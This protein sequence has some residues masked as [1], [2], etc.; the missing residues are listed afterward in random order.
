MPAY[1]RSRAHEILRER[2]GL[3]ELRP[4]QE[5]VIA[6]VLAGN[7]ALVLWPTGSG[8]SLCFQL[9]AVLATEPG[10]LTLVLSPLIAL[11]QDQV[12][13]LRARGIDATFLNSTLSRSERDKRQDAIARGRY[14][15][16]YV[17]PERFRKSEFRKAIANRTVALLAVD[18]AHCI[19]EWGHDF[20]PD[21]GK[22]GEIRRALGDPP[23][24]ALTATATEAT[25]KHI[26]DKLRLV[27]PRVSRRSVTREN[28][29][30]GVTE[31]HDEEEKLAALARRVST[32]PGAGIVYCA[33]IR[34]LENIR[35]HLAP[36]GRRLMLYHGD[37]PTALRARMQRE[38]L[39]ANDAVVIATNAF[40]MGVDKP[41]IRFILHAQIPGSV[42]AYAQEIGRAGRDGRTSHCELF[43]REEDLLI[44]K[45][46]IEWAN[47]G[48]RFLEQVLEV[49]RRFGDTLHARERDDV[50]AE[51]LVKNRGDMRV[52]TALA[53]LDSAGILRGS[54]ETK[55]LRIERE[56]TREELEMLAPA[57]K[58]GRDLE[59][60]L[61]MVRYARVEGC[62]RSAIERYFDA[63]SNPADCGT[64]DR[65]DPDGKARP[66]PSVVST[67][68]NK[69]LPEPQ[70]DSPVRVGEWILLRGRQAVRVESIRAHRDGFTIRGASADDFRVREYDLSKVPWEPM[71]GS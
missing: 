11:M 39:E 26:A 42:E 56:P 29:E 60:L 44:Q 32:L 51:L 5:A 31:V 57:D 15:L 20:R 38:F 50:V 4:D 25:A 33:L 24:L 59:R 27:E 19:S 1:E 13:G 68:P 30:L 14:P 47:P 53:V 49:L 41:D 70:G 23:T 35:Q 48:A 2:F 71:S 69:G 65:C 21:Y 40:G 52:D 66:Q 7:D 3:A 18:E 17:T 37:L 10:A 9:P 12:E 62:R 58:R 54:F 63:G 34:D 46:F 67:S 43:Y 64:C 36:T 28:L 55:D 6:H 22:V 16:V 45:Q 61:A 8:K